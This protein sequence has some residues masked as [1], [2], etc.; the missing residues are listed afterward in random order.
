MTGTITGQMVPYGR[1]KMYWR[2]GGTIVGSSS[3]IATL[4][5]TAPGGGY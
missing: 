5:S 3:N 1:L 2:V 4:T